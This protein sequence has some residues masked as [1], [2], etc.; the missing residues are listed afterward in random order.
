MPMAVSVTAVTAT[1]ATLA[2]TG[3]AGDGSIDL[4]IAA[5]PDFS[6]CV[7]PVLSIARASPVTILGLNQRATLFVRCRAR[8][9][10]GV[11]EDWSDIET[12][13][14]SDGTARDLSPAPVMIEPTVLVIPEKATSWIGSSEVA[15][16]PAANLGRDAPVGWKAIDLQVGGN[17]DFSQVDIKLSGAPINT[18]AALNTNMPEDGTVFISAAPTRAGL[19]SGAGRVII[20]NG[21]AFRASADLPGRPGYHGLFRFAAVA[22]PWWRVAFRGSKPGGTLWVEHLVLGLARQSKNHSIDKS[23]APISRGTIER[24]RSG[25][26]DRQ[27][28][29]PMR[30]VEFDISFMTEAQYEQ[31]YADLYR[32]ENEAVLVIPNSRAGSFLHDRILFGDMKASRSFNPVSPRFTRSFSIESLI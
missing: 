24:Q 4:Q 22:Q 18:I 14:T 23:E 8:R 32:F 9:A 17:P 27:A 5:R 16:F 31:S 7:C 13:R 1:T 6:F 25:I 26:P 2:F 29:L 10:T 20:N 15:G 11:P 3:L 19:D 30:K 28:G 21:G 12:F